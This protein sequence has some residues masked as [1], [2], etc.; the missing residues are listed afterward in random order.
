MTVA[1]FNWNTKTFLCI[2]KIYL[3]QCCSTSSLL[4]GK[5]A[6]IMLLCCEAAQSSEQPVAHY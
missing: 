5:E 3:M 1:E 6:K 4:K 2:M